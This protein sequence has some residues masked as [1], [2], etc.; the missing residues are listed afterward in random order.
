MKNF[1][2]CLL[3]LLLPLVA[4]AAFS[5]AA[6]A[7]K[8]PAGIQYQ[9][10]PVPRASDDIS[11]TAS[12]SST[13]EDGTP[14]R[15]PLLLVL[16]IVLIVAIFG[17]KAYRDRAR[18]GTGGGRLSKPA[19]PLALMGAIIVGA[20]AF[21]AGGTT[22]A[23]SPKAPKGFLGIAPQEG[24]T[25]VDTA[26]MAAGG[27]RSIRTPIS[28]DIVQ[29]DSAD[30]FD[31]G[32][33]DQSFR[34]GAEA[35]IPILPVLYATPSWVA[36]KTT[37]LPTSAGQI[38]AWRKF[39]AA[40]VQR[41]G[42]GGEF[43][44]EPEQAGLKETPPKSWQLWNEVNFHYFAA[45]VSAKNYGR[46]V[47]AASPVVRAN[48]PSADV[49]LSGLFGR[50]KGNASKAVDAPKFL[51]QLSA[52]VKP[53]TI[54]S[55]ALHPYSPNTAALK[56]LIADF[57]SSANKAG[58]RSKPIHVTEIGWGSGKKT[59]TFLLGSEAKQ[60]AQLKSALGFL[61]KSRKQYKIA[62]AYW[63][64]WKDTDPKGVNCSF[65][66]TIGLFKY[67]A[68]AADGGVRPLKPKAAWKAF[69]GISGGQAG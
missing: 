63:Y 33:Y 26:R 38:S 68:P 29:P 45:P 5:P 32:L 52:Y 55:I 40:A 44:K 43:W 27:I 49:M 16:A 67:T 20:L 69:V 19:V 2:R 48:D 7:E 47:N 1:K 22:A 23:P 18:R 4:F 61:V 59:N 66:Y 54:D 39:V 58:Y 36:R 60:A 57:R 21:G 10:D 65:C 28:W 25:S 11:A 13:S 64:A 30:D 9:Y 41:Y 50:P 56:G 53:K 15:F 42:A 34:A 6:G 62:S 51:K 14:S 24:I 37:T 35:G 17:A 12:P 8:A 31:W 46:M 3:V